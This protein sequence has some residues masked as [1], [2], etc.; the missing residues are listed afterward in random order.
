MLLLT[1]FFLII[2]SNANEQC[3]RLVPNTVEKPYSKNDIFGCLNTLTITE[4]KKNKVLN[5]LKKVFDAY[6]YKDI[7]K[8]E[9]GII[10]PVNIDEEIE[11]LKKDK[12]TKYYE[13]WNKIS[14]FVQKI[15]DGHTNIMSTDEM[16]SKIIYYYPF[17]MYI[18]NNKNVYLIPY[19]STE[20][21]FPTDEN[22][23][24]LSVE[25]INGVSPIEYMR[26][27][28]NKHSFMKNENSRFTH[29]KGSYIGILSSTT[30]N[31]EDFDDITV[32]YAGDEKLYTYHFD[33]VVNN[34]E[35][36]Q[37][38]K[39]KKETGTI[40]AQV[41]MKRKLGK[42]AEASF[43]DHEYTDI[44]YCKVTE[45]ANVLVLKQF[46]SL[47]GDTLIQCFE[48]FNND[49][50]KNKPLIIIL[51]QNTGGDAAILEYV[52]W[53]INT[54]S[55]VRLID[56][57]RVS[58]TSKE[59][60]DETLY[61]ESVFYENKTCKK[62]DTDYYY[63]QVTD[64]YGKRTKPVFEKYFN[65]ADKSDMGG[66]VRRD[67]RQIVVFTDGFCYSCCSCLVQ[68]MK[69]LGNAIIVGFDGNP[70]TE[71]TNFDAGQ[72]CSSVLSSE[73]MISALPEVEE[74]YELGFTMS[75]TF[76]ESYSNNYKFNEVIPM[77]FMKY[78]IDDRFEYYGQFDETDED[79]FDKF[80]TKGLEII[81]KYKE[82]CNPQNDRLV[83][84]ATECD[85]KISIE[86]AHGGYKCGNDGKWS[87]E[88]IAT[89]CD[90]GYFYDFTNKECVEN[91][92]AIDSSFG[93][94][95]IAIIALIMLTF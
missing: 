76:I 79:L 11:N 2:C 40:N 33:F 38:A 29:I 3:E 17:Q 69:E 84:R 92:C 68:K 91:I 46:S 70:Y 6:V 42:K 62:I 34:F 13:F 50:N 85:S 73:V 37:L 75:L 49:K 77:E 89:Y 83:K 95:I 21:E 15:H 94:M 4:E 63:N 82:K 1:L 30:M 41:Y 52:R 25:K 93:M 24:P 71:N 65:E 55:D 35:A 80:T 5:I 61:F 88:C 51:P 48:D 7:I 60:L 20:Q 90:E 81:E 26:E 58:E 9:T 8:T 14:R 54:D 39:E 59:I 28:G 31:E 23:I 74:L 67:P 45:K 22:G 19:Y 57:T 36:K 78:P 72:S 16:L 43:Y 27:L 87:T 53:M 47:S 64:K 66:N 18:K 12:T 44:V 56:S 32:K 86:H 10:D